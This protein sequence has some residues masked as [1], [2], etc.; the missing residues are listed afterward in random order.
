MWGLDRDAGFVCSFDGLES[1]ASRGTRASGT[2]T[3]DEVSA[4]SDV[5]NLEM[6]ANTLNCFGQERI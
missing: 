5:E 1:I 4:L 3:R 2:Q 6:D